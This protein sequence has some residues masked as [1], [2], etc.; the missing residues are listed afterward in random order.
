MGLGSL[1]GGIASAAG[2]IFGGNAISGAANNAAGYGQGVYNTVESQL[3]PNIGAGQSALYS[4]ASLLG[5][6]GVPKPA[7]AGVGGATPQQAFQ[8]WTQTPYYQ[9][10]LQQG[11]LALQRSNASSGLLNSGATAKQLLQYAT[12]YAS[13][14]LGGY[15]GQLQGLVSGGQSAALGG[16][17]VGTGTLGPVT[18]SLLTGG[19]AQAAGVGSA[20]QSIF[21]NQGALTPYL[22]SAFNSSS[23]GNN[24]GF[25]PSA[26]STA[27]QFGSGWG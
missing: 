15:L 21:G 27:Y 13:Q 17:Q 8:S 26:L 2:S 7:G 14:G 3:A 16:G 19:G 1:I 24:S 22:N 12:G 23:Y 18:N 11:E 9:F 10:P 5:I 6:G 25:S 20:L 4:L